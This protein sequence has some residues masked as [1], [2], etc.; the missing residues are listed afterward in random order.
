MLV[1]LGNACRDVTYRVDRLP[2][3]GETIN[4]RA[5]LTDLGG[6][7][8]NQAVA[9]G[10]AGAR[11]RLI[12]AVGDDAVAAEI[13]ALLAREGISAADLLVRPGRSDMSV[14]TIDAGAE[15]TIV[16][17][18]ALAEGITEAE[19]ASALDLTAG[20]VLLMQGNLTRLATR[21]G[22]LHARSR[23]ARVIVNPA[24]FDTAFVELGAFVDVLILNALEARQWTG[25]DAAEAAVDALPA[26]IAVV[27]LGPAGC[28]LRVGAERPRALR[29][30]A[31]EA[32]DTTGAGDTFTGVF[33]GEWAASGDAV[34]AATLALHA[35][36]EKVARAGTTSALPARADI[37]R[38]RATLFPGI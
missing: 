2:A 7:G 28:L 35:A 8:L 1:V 16:S 3:P 32:V 6:K 36:S 5:V 37:E 9:A 17:D 29:A 18:C 27:T 4:A 21:A 10:R 24:P 14:I 20:D 30:P 15:N 13:R 26:D 34:R 31:V 38:M 11:V 33:A 25:L 22:A 12:T 23:G 19:V